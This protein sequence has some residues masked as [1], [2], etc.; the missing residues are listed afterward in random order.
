MPL[1]S[2]AVERNLGPVLCAHLKERSVGMPPDAAQQLRSSYLEAAARNLRL[3]HE[4]TKILRLFHDAGLP[5]IP[6]KGAFLAEAVYGDVALRPMADLDLLVSP[7]DM[8]RALRLLRTISYESDHE[9]DPVSEQAVSQH[10]PLMYGPNGLVVELHWTIVLPLLRTGFGKAELN[11]L[12]DRAVPATIAGV[13]AQA[14]CPTDLLLHLCLHV[15]AQHRFDG[16]TFQGLVD[17]AAVVKR[18]ADA[19]DWEV[20]ASRTRRWGVANAVH[21]AL[22]MAGEYAHCP[23]PS[24]ALAAIN[25]DPV[26]DET[27]DWIREKAAESSPLPLKSNALRLGDGTG[28]LGKLAAVRDSVFLPRTVMG[29]MYAIPANSWRVLAYYPVR[30]KDLLAR[31]H[32][33]LWKLLRRDKAF[34]ADARREARLREYLGWP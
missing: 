28:V 25:A 29:R 17:I 8:P 32:A 11:K 13:P 7:S 33:T 4:L 24:S 1:V 10:M 18:Y 26:S 16:A 22:Q 31:Y 12:W 34:V 9:F 6:L 5:V 19:I 15:S 2:F 3:F 23:Y 20:F 21:L 27:L 14:L 30:I